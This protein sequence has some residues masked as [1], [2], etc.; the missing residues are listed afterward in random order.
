MTKLTDM[1]AILLS[2]ASQRPTGSLLPIPDAI[3]DKEAEAFKNIQQL[4]KR[5]LATEIEVQE[6]SE[7]YREDGER[8]LA[9]LITDVGKQAI[10]AVDPK[11]GDQP[12][13][14]ASGAMPSASKQSKVLALL[15]RQQGASVTELQEATGWLPHTTRAALTGMRKRGTELVKRKVDGVTRYKAVVAQ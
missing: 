13:H 3:A 8:R 11:A 15:Q 12:L 1:Q 6:K 2:N 7:V 10:G 5:K 9:A 14:S 4:I